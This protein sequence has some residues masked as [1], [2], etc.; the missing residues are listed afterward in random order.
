MHELDEHLQHYG[1]KGMKWGVVRD[2]NRPGGADGKD[3][4]G[5][6]NPTTIKGKVDQKLNSLKRER[7][8]SKVLKEVDKMTTKDINTVK[9][10][11]D[12]ENSLKDL[13]K[14]KI[15]TKK[16]KQDYL[17][18][19]K[20]S[21]EELSRKVT[22]LKAKAGLYDSVYSASKGQ[23]DFGEKVVKVASSVGYKYAINKTI[24]PKDI[25]DAYANPNDDKYGYGKAKDA[26]LRK[27][28]NPIAS[29]VVDQGVKKIEGSWGDKKSKPSE[30]K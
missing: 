22:R 4:K 29:F 2:R 10:R 15:A 25:F 20:M 17:N 28:K 11:I 14:Y 13:T 21:N 1:V 30:R 23:R 18:R 7:Q 6:R 27:V 24:T 19:D 16:D 5:T 3:E 26:A 9:K 12:L 8:W